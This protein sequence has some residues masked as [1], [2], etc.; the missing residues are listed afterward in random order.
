[1]KDQERSALAAR[2]A[3][4]L[5]QHQYTQLVNENGVEV[6]RCQQPGT[7]VYHFDICVTAY[8]MS[9]FGD[10]DG[11]LWHVGADYGINFLRHQSDGY[12]HEKLE[13]AC[14]REVID[15]DSIRDTVCSCIVG[16][17]DE[18]FD[19]DQI[20]EGISNIPDQGATLDQAELLVG[21]LRDQE[22]AGARAHLGVDHQYISLDEARNQLVPGCAI[23]L[24]IP[25]HWNGNDIALARWPIG[26][27]YRFE[28]AHHL[29]LEVAEAIGNT[30]EEAVIWPLAYLEAKSR[31]LVHKRD[32]N[33]K[34]AL[35]G[36]GIELVKP[37]GRRTPTSIQNCGGCGRFVPSPSYED[38]R[39]CDHDNRP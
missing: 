6:W 3:E 37:R 30:P 19:A 31:R 33:I 9:M 38:C 17:I 14:K 32:V 8:G 25:D 1:M 24:Q 11:L 2:V 26:H 4:D 7:R 28:R 29:T 22:E 5:A 16:R 34:E 13:S 35:Q 23:V 18:E 10:I 27:T 39:H 12:L 20:P 21:W 36:T 15:F